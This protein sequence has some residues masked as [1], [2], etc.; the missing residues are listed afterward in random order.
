MKN[1][2]FLILIALLVSM[3]TP[4]N[5]QAQFVLPHEVHIA[6]KKAYIPQ[7]F[8]SNDRVQVVVEG[9]LPNTCYRLGPTKVWQ[10]SDPHDLFVEQHAY[11]YPGVCLEVIVPFNHSIEFGILPAGNYNI[12]NVFV[13]ESGTMTYEKSLGT[14]P[15]ATA[16]TAGPDDHLYAIVDDATLT[17]SSE[18]KKVV[19]TGELPGPCWFFE[20][21]KVVVESNDVVT[22]LPIIYYKVP[23][24]SLTQC[25]VNVTV[26]FT[27]AVTL[28]KLPTGRY[29]IQTRSL[30]G[31]SVNKLFN[32]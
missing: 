9:F 16:A 29:L 14:I 3:L 12:K 28:P 6:L 22:I 2:F 32:L 26:P 18:S 15:V 31:Q 30:N 4:K 24:D 8:D 5:S 10:G 27:K 23:H 21:T 17:T 11:K 7:G 1:T 13:E 19:L 25:D 20:D